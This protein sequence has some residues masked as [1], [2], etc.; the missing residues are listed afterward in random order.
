M[1]VQAVDATAQACHNM[2]ELRVALL[3][4]LIAWT[5][6]DVTFRA[7]LRQQ[8]EQGHKDLQ[9]MKKMARYLAETLGVKLG[10]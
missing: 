6:R 1:I 9:N 3:D 7:H 5:D 10:M 4:A 2:Q 8:V